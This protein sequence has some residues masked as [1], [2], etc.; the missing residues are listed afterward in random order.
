MN[1]IVST[2]LDF[3]AV[4]A[5]DFVDMQRFMR[6]VDSRTCDYTL[7]GVVL[8]TDYFGYKIARSGG[9]LY[10]LGGREDDLRVPAFALPLGGDLDAA[11]CQLRAWC[12]RQGTELWLSAV[13]EDRLHLFASIPGVE[14]TELDSRWSDYLYDIAPMA[15]LRGNAMKRK[16]NHV[17]RF[18][19]E[20]ESDFAFEP[21][22][23]RNV[24]GCLGLLQRMGH[25]NTPT[26]RAEYEAV[27]RML[28]H[29][30]D[31]APCFSGA[32]LSIGDRVAGFTV[33]EV[34]GDTLHVHIEKADHEIEG[35]NEALTSLFARTMLA[36]D[37]RLRFVNRQ[38]DA[39]DEGLRA[40]KMSWR[41]LRLLPKFNVR[42]M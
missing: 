30:G 5:D 3:R 36:R 16:R 34:K 10:I 27:E 25:D 33:G 21:L 9:T 12:D 18:M 26:G 39:G 22:A 37:G 35:V 11:L 40:S 1:A 13:P 15:G 29:Y 19:A 38:D 8:W 42:L 32:V 4:T 20:H 14:V 28:R 31:Y 41:P 23:M 6:S 7:G 17:N 24:A 2:I